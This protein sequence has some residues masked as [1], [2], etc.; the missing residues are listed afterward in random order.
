MD[1]FIHSF[2]HSLKNQVWSLCEVAAPCSLLRMQVLT[3]KTQLSFGQLWAQCWQVGWGGHS[4]PWQPEA[5]LVYAP[6]PTLG[7]SLL[8]QGLAHGAAFCPD[9]PLQIPPSLCLGLEPV[10]LTQTALPFPKAASHWPGTHSQH[11]GLVL[12][13]SSLNPWIVTY[14]K[15]HRY[16]IDI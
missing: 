7:S 12:L 15:S 13:I 4:R 14:F 3:D 9:L 16:E 1:S 2:T 8:P 10:P 6:C 5:K 11:P